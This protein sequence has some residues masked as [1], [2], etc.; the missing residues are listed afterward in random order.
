MEMEQ[1][2]YDGLLLLLAL[3]TRTWFVVG[4][5]SLPVFVAATFALPAGRKVMTTK[6]KET[7]GALCACP[8]TRVTAGES[9]IIEPATHEASPFDALT[10]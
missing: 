5:L 1:K 8:L 2:V 10:W 4:V 7:L 9:G 3:P 6:V